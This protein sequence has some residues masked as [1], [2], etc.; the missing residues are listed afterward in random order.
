MEFEAKLMLEAKGKWQARS[1]EMIDTLAVCRS[2]LPLLLVKL[3]L[4]AS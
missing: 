2:K 1:T 3:G 4:K